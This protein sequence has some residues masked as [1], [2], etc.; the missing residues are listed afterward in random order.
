[1]NKIEQKYYV[2]KTFRKL[3]LKINNVKVIQ[4]S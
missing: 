2:K 4:M 3:T 1:M